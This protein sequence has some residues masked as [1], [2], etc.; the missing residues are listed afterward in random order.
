[1]SWRCEDRRE[2]WDAWLNPRAVEMLLS[3]TSVV[4]NTVALFV[5]IREVFLFE[6][7]A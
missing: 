2:G 5:M 7:G 3:P 4:N 6:R 1:M